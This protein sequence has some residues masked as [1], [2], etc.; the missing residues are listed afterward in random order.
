MDSHA[1]F[2]LTASDLAALPPDGAGAD[3]FPA[4]QRPWRWDEHG[5]VLAPRARVALGPVDCS[6][7][8]F[9]KVAA[10][11]GSTK[12]LF[13]FDGDRVETVHMPRNDR[14]TMCVSSQ[15]GCAIG[16]RFCATATMG[17]RRHL[18]A[19]E[20]VVQVLTTMY[21][22]GPRHPSE[23][24]L[25]FMGMGEPLHN[26]DNVLRAIEILCDVRGLG[27]APKRIT[28]STSGLVPQIDAL[29]RAPVRPLLALS[30]NATTDALRRDLMPI[31]QRYSLA[32]LAAA[33]E[34]FPLRPKERVL[35][36]YVLLDG[37]NDT[38]EDAQ[39]LAEFGANFPHHINLIPFNAHSHSPYRAPSQ[40]RVAAFAKAV[41]S[42]RPTFVTVRKSRARDVQGACGQL[43]ILR[44]GQAPAVRRRAPA[45]DARP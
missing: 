42:H 22:C 19:A 32:D 34:R 28:V 33:L 31:G 37:V 7:P 14:V 8:T 2:G 6:L 26:L 24:T 13:T 29:G 45:S 25:V 30:L 18:S 3:A 15:V 20:I 4:L 23:L 27:L 11:D 5:P 39:R 10:S 41:L 17:F 36:E 40:E 44:A 21:A 12:L 43:V 1:A 38:L 35:L 16:C 9:E